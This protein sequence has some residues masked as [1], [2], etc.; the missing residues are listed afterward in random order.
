LRED[1]VNDPGR[2]RAVRRFRRALGLLIL[3]FVVTCGAVALSRGWRLVVF[4][5]AMNIL[6]LLYGLPIRIPGAG[7]R[8]Y[9]RIK[10]VVILKNVYSSLFWS[11]ALILTP[12]L[13]VSIAPGGVAAYLAALAFVFAMYVELSWD[14]RDTCGDAS[15]GVSTIPVV[16]GHNVARLALHGLNVA[17]LAGVIAGLAWGVLPLRFF[18]LVVPCLVNVAVTECLAFPRHREVLSH[19]HLAVTSAAVAMIVALAHWSP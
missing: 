1:A 8:R 18:P 12:H 15:Q 17:A 5:T 3:A 9:V 14:V 2:A 16:F 7:D 6:G 19:L 4:G 11:A 10:N 13:Y